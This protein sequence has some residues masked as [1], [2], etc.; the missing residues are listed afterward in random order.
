M[1]AGATPVELLRGH[2]GRG[3]EH[4]AA[5]RDPGAV[6]RRGD[7]EVGELR[8]AVLPDQHVAG[9][10][11]AV[12]H[13]LGMRVVERVAQ[14]GDHPRDLLGPQRTAPQEPRERLPV[15]VL[16]DD[17]DAL[18]VGRGVEHRDQVRMVQRRPEL[19]LAVEALCD[20]LRAIGVQALHG[21]LAAEPLVLAQENGGHASRAEMPD[22]PIPVV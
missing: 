14:L 15:H 9:L 16:H 1:S 10:H 4:R 7:P 18:V 12:H 3:A 17:Q 20:V 11:V 5:P 19:R 21:H 13:A 2:V 8:D 22:Y 6:R